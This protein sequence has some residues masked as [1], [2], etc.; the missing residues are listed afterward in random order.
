MNRPSPLL[1][2]SAAGVAATAA[3]VMAAVGGLELSGRPNSDIWSNAW[4]VGAVVVAWVGLLSAAALCI[5]AFFGRRGGETDRPIAISNA[6]ESR[7]ADLAVMPNASSQLESANMSDPPIKEAQRPGGAAL[8]I[9]VENEQWSNWRHQAYIVALRIK[10]MN[11]TGDIV[12]LEPARIISE[13]S[14]NSPT[15][16]ALPSGL[17]QVELDQEMGS[18]RRQQYSPDLRAYTYVPPHDSISGWLLSA[19]PYRSTGGRPRLTVVVRDIFGNQYLAVVDQQEP[20][21][22]GLE[23]KSTVEN[24]I[25]PSEANQSGTINTIGETARNKDTTVSPQPIWRAMLTSR[26]AIGIGISLAVI[27]AAGWAFLSSKH[28]NS[29]LTGVV[30]C[31]SGRHVVGVWIAA[32]SGQRASGYA[33]LGPPDITGT[34]YP[35]GSTASFSYLLRGGGSYAIHVGCG[36][37]AKH[38]T[39][40][41]YSPLLSQRNITL[42]CADPVQSGVA[43]NPPQG[44]CEPLA[45]S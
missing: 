17:E 5:A 3:T 28:T 45:S 31:E 43:G 33:H 37:T 36:G 38:W 15:A 25:S 39:S 27:L 21:V 41:N 34:S 22:F 12:R 16:F 20:H 9:V 11:T 13:W 4:I 44:K 6:R 14:D 18:M 26:W 10:I 29:M 30:V 23:G 40:S 2:V 42:R 35:V 19:V 1:A 32:S 8:V 7:I 24:Q